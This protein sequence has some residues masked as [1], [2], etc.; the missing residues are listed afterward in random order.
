LVLRQGGEPSSERVA[1][2]VGLSLAVCALG[3]LV[4]NLF[5]AGLRASTWTALLCAVTVFGAGA[6]L[7]R[8]SRN[9]TARTCVAVR[10]TARSLA[11]WAALVAMVLAFVGALVIARHGAR[12]QSAGD[13]FSQ[14]WMIPEGGRLTLGVRNDEPG[15][16]RVSVSL[17]AEGHLDRSWSVRLAPERAWIEHVRRPSTRPGGRVL[18]RLLVPGER[19]REVWIWTPRSQ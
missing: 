11:N 10:F 12:Q 3:A 9:R 13:S 2:S 1:L 8:R 4:L 18:A 16:R 15:A 5:P 17:V 19:P 6:A 7:A 14:L